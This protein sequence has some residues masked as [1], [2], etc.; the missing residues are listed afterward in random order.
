[1]SE[2]QNNNDLKPWDKNLELDTRRSYEAFQVYLELGDRRTLDKVAEIVDKTPSLIYRWS[3]KGKWVSR[4]EQY[5][6]RLQQIAQDFIEDTRQEIVED[7]KQE[8]I[9]IATQPNTIS[10]H[11]QKLEQY[12]QS[13]EDLGWRNLQLSADCL[14]LVSD[15]LKKY[16]AENKALKPLDVRALAAAGASAS[17]IGERLLTQGLGVMQLLDSVDEILGTQDVIDV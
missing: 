17:E 1:M 4:A 12:R 11:R 6:T 14:D 13:L 8:I 10:T 15:C 3:Q 16:K 2:A 5:D 7:I 9:E